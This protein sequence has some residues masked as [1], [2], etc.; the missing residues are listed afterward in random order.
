MFLKRLFGGGKDYNH[1]LEK[2]DKYLAGERFADAR[3]AYLEALEKLEARGATAGLP[4]EE[5]RRKVAHAG[6]MLGRLNLAEAEYAI[7]SG[8]RK[9]AGE[10]LGI[11]M[12]LADDPAL[13]EHAERLLRELDSGAS[14]QAPPGE[15][16]ACASCEE[17]EDGT[18]DEEHDGTDKA[19]AREDR[20]ALYFHTLPG[21]LPD[22]YA[23][24]GEEFA[25]GC[26]FSLEGDREAALR[27]FET[28]PPDK[29]NDILIYEKAII[30]FHAGDNGACEKLLLKAREQNPANPLCGIGL[31]QLYTET[32]RAHE[33][34]QVVER[35]IADGLEAE[36]A[37]LMQGELHSL[38]KDDSNAVESYSRLLDSPRY[39]KEAAARLVPL[40]QGLGRT[41][42]AA[43]L[44]KKFSKGR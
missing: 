42:E 19:I 35:M 13:R 33:A 8:D 2:G 43:Y 27:V 9:K 34:L 32:G 28:L 21:N 25:R 15:V 20:V 36:Q 18:E 37:R 38:L 29:E 40:L 31:V 6:N 22:R 11:I 23:A 10:H 14:E 5:I 30:H 7:S 24:M 16:P 44:I 12:E 17:S 3:N 26:L 4:A 1:Y 39:A 41:Q